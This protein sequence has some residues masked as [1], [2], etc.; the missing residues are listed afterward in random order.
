MLAA[1]RP[2]LSL[3]ILMTLLCGGLYPALLTAFAHI[4]FPTLAAGSPVKLDGKVVG[5]RLIA[6]ATDDPR[7]FWP[8]PSETAD[9]PTNAMASGGSNMNP[10]NPLLRNKIESRI[11]AL[12]SADPSTTTSVPRD[13]VMASGSG[14]DPDISPENALKQLPRIARLRDLHEDA[15]RHL[16]AA[17]LVSRQFGLL[18]MP[19][20]NVIELN[21]ALDRLQKGGINE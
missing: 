17:H 1:L 18:G 13:S 4:A 19:R 2:V 10:G 7:Y 11:A 3:L 5:S 16:L 9:Y 21:L 6:Q 14:L 8:R 12:R 15:L 20:L